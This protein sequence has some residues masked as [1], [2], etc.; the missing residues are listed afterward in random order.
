MPS[1]LQEDS[2]SLSELELPLAPTPSGSPSREED[3]ELD[4]LFG[5]DNGREYLGG[6]GVLVLRGDEDLVAEKLFLVDP[7]PLLALFENEKTSSCSSSSRPVKRPRG[8]SEM[9]WRDR[10]LSA[11]SARRFQ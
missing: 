1:V 9:F 10:F 4:L 8:F 2:S 11:S 3:D 6:E 5:R 7:R